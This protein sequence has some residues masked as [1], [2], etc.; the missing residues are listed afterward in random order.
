MKKIIFLFLILLSIETHAKYEWYDCNN[1]EQ[2]KRCASGCSKSTDATR[3][4]YDFKVNVNSNSVIMNYFDKDGKYLSSSTFNKCSVID[5]KNW[6]CSNGDDINAI[7]HE[8]IFRFSFVKNQC[9][10]DS[11]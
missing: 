11:F 1:A 5:T 9:Y 7:M 4:V 6:I 2:T 3:K 8:A 10:K